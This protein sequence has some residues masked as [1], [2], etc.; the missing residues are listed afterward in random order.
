M[1]HNVVQVA[2]QFMARRSRLRVLDT[3]KQRL[4][5]QN[6][7]QETV[8]LHAQQ[9]VVF[10]WLFKKLLPNLQDFVILVASRSHLL[11]L[12]SLLDHITQTK[13]IE[14]LFWRFLHWCYTPLHNVSIV[15]TPLLFYDYGW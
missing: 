12:T 8:G 2:N 4:V 10:Y 1:M 15:A 11:K 5:I 9:P 6:I 13:S 7:A 14:S 3:A